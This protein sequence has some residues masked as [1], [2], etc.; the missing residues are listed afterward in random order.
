MTLEQL[1][2]LGHATAELQKA[3]QG[4]AKRRPVALDTPTV[5]KRVGISGSTLSRAKREGKLPYQVPFEGKT[6]VIDFA[7][8]R[9]NKDFWRLEEE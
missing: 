1:T 7:Y 2:L 8:R 3:L 6:A 5:A 4:S 9:K